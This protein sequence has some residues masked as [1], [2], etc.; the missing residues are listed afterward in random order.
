MLSHRLRREIIAT[1]VTNSLVNRMGST[2]L[3]R[4][5]EDTG[6]T[7]SQIA[8][9]Y[10]IIRESMLARELWAEIDAL[11]HKVSEKVQLDALAGIWHLQRNLTRWLIAL[12]GLLLDIARMVERYQEPFSTLLQSLPGAL[13]PGDRSIFDAEFSRL[14]KL[15]MTDRLAHFLAA[16]PYLN[17][18]MDI[19]ELSL[20]EKQPVMAVAQAHFALSDAL[21]INWLM[22]NVELLPVT[23]RWQAQARGVLRDEL[24]AQQRQLVST[25]LATAVAGKSPADWVSSWLSRDDAALKYTLGMFTDMRS[26][27]EMDFPTL[28][29]AVRRLAQ[30]A[31]T[32]VR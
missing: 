1:A 10:T 3:L 7:P 32:G 26:L 5:Q 18:A 23:G 31:S 12:P 6:E 27:S 22:E 4:M 17:S 25:V 20:R 15:G 14:S 29:V 30:I 9:A 2:F 21:H 24:Q 28:S 16:L 11:D 19:I 8:K 13:T